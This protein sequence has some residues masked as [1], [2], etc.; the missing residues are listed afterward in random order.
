MFIRKFETQ[1]HLLDFVNASGGMEPPFK[2]IDLGC[3]EKVFDGEYIRRRH[4]A[5]SYMSPECVMG[6]YDM[7]TDIWSA[8]VM[9]RLLN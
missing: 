6:L 4:G 8:G 3:C 2:A 1:Q 9:V 7:K 5:I